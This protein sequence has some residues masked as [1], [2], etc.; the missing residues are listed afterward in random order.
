MNKFVYPVLSYEVVDGDTVKTVLDLG[1]QTTKF[2]SVRIQDI[3]TPEKRTR[4]K[5]EKQAGLSATFAVKKW[6]ECRV[7]NHG[8][9]L[10]VISTEL[11]KY[12]GRIVGDIYSLEQDAATLSS[13][14]LRRGWAR[15][16]DGGRKKKWSRAELKEIIKQAELDWPELVI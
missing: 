2:V 5:L 12:A 16:Y 4:D 8:Y 10:M 14:M 11:G 13:Y 6:L 7:K 1:F 15:V 3:D 9:T